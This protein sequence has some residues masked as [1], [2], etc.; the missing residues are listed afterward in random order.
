MSYPWL[1]KY[2]QR[3]DTDAGERRIRVVTYVYG[4]SRQ[5]GQERILLELSIREILE[6]EMGKYLRAELTTI[7]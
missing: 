6:D 5:L 4:F 2:V 7:Q 1:V 3:Y